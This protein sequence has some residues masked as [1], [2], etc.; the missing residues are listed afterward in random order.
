MFEITAKEVKKEL[1]RIAFFIQHSGLFDTFS[2]HTRRTLEALPVEWE[3]VQVDG[4][5][6]LKWQDEPTWA[7]ADLVGTMN[8][9]PVEVKIKRS[10]S[11]NTYLVS[12]SGKKYT[13]E[14]MDALRKLFDDLQEGKTP[15]PKVLQSSYDLLN[16]KK[17]H[18]NSQAKHY[19][20]NQVT[21]KPWKIDISKD[22]SRIFVKFLTSAVNSNELDSF[23]SKLEEQDKFRINSVGSYIKKMLQKDGIDVSELTFT[24]RLISTPGKAGFLI[25]IK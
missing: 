23:N 1:K 15:K 2:P 25:T 8:D 17:T 20:L 5:T 19:Y 10:S 22:S 16:Q 3:S 6:N 9:E 4:Q 13:V 24:Q 11:R 7:E 12:Y 14:N 21:E 18:L